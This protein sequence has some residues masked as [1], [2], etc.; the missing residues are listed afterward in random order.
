MKKPPDGGFF[1]IGWGTRMTHA[2][3]L[4]PAGPSSLTLRCY[5][6]PA[7]CSFRTFSSTRFESITCENKEGPENRAF[8]ILAGEQ[9]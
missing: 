3:A 2:K 6:Q 9:G 7:G 1:I 5:S 4:A 8:F